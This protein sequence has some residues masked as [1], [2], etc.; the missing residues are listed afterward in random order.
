MDAGCKEPDAC[1]GRLPGVRGACCGHGDPDEAYICMGA[2]DVREPHREVLNGVLAL[3]RIEA[4]KRR[5]EAQARIKEL[6]AEIE[7]LRQVT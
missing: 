6:E 5:R 7:A 4:L 3:E 1:I 2:N